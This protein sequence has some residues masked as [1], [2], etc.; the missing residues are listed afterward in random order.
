MIHLKIIVSRN[1]GKRFFQASEQA[2]DAIRQVIERAA[3]MIDREAKILIDRGSK[4]GR[5]YGRHQASAPGEAPATDTG[6][7]IQS[8]QWQISNHGF[9]AEVGSTV[10][11]APLLEEGTDSM[12]ARPWL[13]PAYEPHV[14]E[15]I[16][17]MM[18]TLKRQL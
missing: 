11:Y 13:R 4:S 6:R 8:I 10:F 12:A 1:Q 17:D 5:V 15:I 14:D 3:L 18:N 7:L 9:T 2:M 16:E